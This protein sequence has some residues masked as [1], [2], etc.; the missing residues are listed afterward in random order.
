MSNATL[1]IA[2]AAILLSTPLATAEEVSVGGATSSAQSSFDVTVNVTASCKLTTQNIG[3]TGYTYNALNTTDLEIEN[4]SAITV[5]CNSG[6]N[7]YLSSS[8]TSSALYNGSSY[9]SYSID[10]NNGAGLPSNAVST[11]GQDV[12]SAKV[13]IPKNQTQAAVGTYTGTVTIYIGLLN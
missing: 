7:Y 5:Q 13:T 9:L 2:L 12:Y 1:R 3:G 6:A 11:G 8:V 10:F 4:P